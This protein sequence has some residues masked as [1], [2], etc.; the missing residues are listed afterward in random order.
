MTVIVIVTVWINDPLKTGKVKS[1]SSERILEQCATFRAWHKKDWKLI[2]KH[3]F[4]LKSF[5]GILETLPGTEKAALLEF[6]HF[7]VCLRKEKYKHKWLSKAGYQVLSKIPRS[8][9]YY[10]CYRYIRSLR[11][12]VPYFICRGQGAAT[13]RLPHT[14]PAL[15]SIYLPSLCVIKY[16][17]KYSLTAHLALPENNFLWAINRLSRRF[18]PQTL[19]CSILLTP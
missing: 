2:P 16:V 17:R 6:K 3:F 9:L 15:R 7:P 1:C 18:P 12:A 13:R 14:F 11:V 5:P 19:F 4:E 10:W 8:R